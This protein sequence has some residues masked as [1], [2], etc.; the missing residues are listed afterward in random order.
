M[1]GVEFAPNLRREH[2]LVGIAKAKAV[3]VYKGREF[4]GEARDHGTPEPGR[5]VGNLIESATHALRL[6]A[7]GGG[8]R[9]GQWGRYGWC[10]C[11]RRRLL[12]LGHW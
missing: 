5:R 3:G 10:R 1:L 9:F 8:R 11:G 2:Q 6:H 12:W 4:K 7:P